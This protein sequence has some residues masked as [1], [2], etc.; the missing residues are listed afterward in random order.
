MIYS[1]FIINFNDKAVLGR[2]IDLLRG[3]ANMEV[4]EGVL[5]NLVE[6]SRHYSIR[7][8]L[9]SRKLLSK[10]MKNMNDHIIAIISPQTS[11]SNLRK[12]ITSSMSKDHH[13][14]LESKVL[15]GYTQL[16]IALASM[17]NS[18]FYIPGETKEQ[19]ALRRKAIL[20]GLI[21]FMQFLVH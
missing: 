15:L 17:S 7:G 14:D 10:I 6:L 13:S 1:Q 21:I 19:Q 11:E 16:L 20:N 2:L 9:L 5:K 8:T 12:S 18:R 4:R 3:S